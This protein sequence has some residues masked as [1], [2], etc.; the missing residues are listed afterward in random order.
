MKVKGMASFPRTVRAKP[1]EVVVFSWIAYQS[2]AQRNRVNAKIMKDPRMAGFDPA[3]MPFDVKRMRYGG[4][5][6][7][8]DFD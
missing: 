5:R 8:V 7:F 2:K 6:V 3:K 4:F 1:G